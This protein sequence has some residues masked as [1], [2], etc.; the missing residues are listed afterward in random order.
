M[1]EKTVSET[2]NIMDQLLT[3]EENRRNVK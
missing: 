2:L 1:D 3:K